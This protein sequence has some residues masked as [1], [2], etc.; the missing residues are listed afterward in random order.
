MRRPSPRGFTLIE[1]LV[2]AL[3]LGIFISFVYGA[4]VSAFN[5]RGVVQATTSAMTGGTV[6]VEVVARDLENAFLVPLKGADAFKAVDEGGDRSRIDFLTT[7]D[8]R[9]QQEIARR[10]LRSDVTE[11]GYRLRQGDRGWTLFRREQFGVDDKPLE[12]G[13]YYKV[14]AGVKEFRLDFF[15]K[16]PSEEG[17]DEEKDALRE[18]DAKEKRKLPRSVK[19]TLAIEGFSTDPA[20]SDELVEY[21]FTRWVVLPGAF[22]TEKEKEAA[23]GNPPGN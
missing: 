20:R 15:E 17:G 23:G 3:V 2:G 12:G 5:V 18:W 16:D 11:T 4:V 7:L 21:R 22:D 9:G 19:I 13:D 1:V 10:M 8:S 6:A 14:L